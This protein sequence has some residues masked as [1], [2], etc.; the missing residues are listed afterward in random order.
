M[1]D[2][3]GPNRYLPG[4]EI[5]VPEGM[6][7]DEHDDRPAT[8][9]IVGETD[10]FG[11]ELIDWCDECYEKYKKEKTEGDHGSGITSCDHCSASGVRTTTTR[12]PD[13]GSCGPVYYLC[14]GC[15]QRLRDYHR[16]N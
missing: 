11:S 10:S 3:I 6:T 1:A 16:D 14:D 7:C 12:D 2:V 5:Q 4:Q 15:L 13:E 9:R 8:H